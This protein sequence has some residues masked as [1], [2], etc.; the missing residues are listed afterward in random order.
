MPQVR[1]LTSQE[2][3]ILE[4]ADPSLRQQRD[5]HY[6]ALLHPFTV[7]DYGIAEALPGESRLAVRRRLAA[8][9]ARRGWALDFL[10]V[11]EDAL[12]FHVR[13]LTEK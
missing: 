12:Y 13:E 1:K 5:A 8:A 7:G 3:Q 10:S 11:L 9:A 2:S 4:H 6:D